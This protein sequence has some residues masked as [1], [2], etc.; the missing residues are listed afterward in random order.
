MSEPET[1]SHSLAQLPTEL[2]AGHEKSSTL[3]VCSRTAWIETI[4]RLNG[5]VHWPAVAGVAAAA[6]ACAGAPSRALSEG[7]PASA[8]A[9]VP[10]SKNVRRSTWL[11]VP[12][13]GGAR[14]LVLLPA[15]ER[16]AG[17]DSLPDF[18]CHICNPHHLDTHHGR[19]D[20]TRG[21]SP[22]LIRASR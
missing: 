5:A 16:A 19:G 10:A 14:P 12:A 8:A 18:L 3:P 2:L 20:S 9:A 17:A 6:R 11:V 22:L 13:R 1:G 21:R 15:E 4:P 7:P